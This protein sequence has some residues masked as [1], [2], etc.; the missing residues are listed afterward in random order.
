MWMPFFYDTLMVYLFFFKIKSVCLE[1]KILV[2][3]QHGSINSKADPSPI[4]SNDASSIINYKEKILKTLVFGMIQKK[5]RTLSLVWCVSSWRHAWGI[6][7]ELSTAREI[8]RPYC[9]ISPRLMPWCVSQAI[10]S[11]SFALSPFRNFPLSL[12]AAAVFF[13]NSLQCSLVYRLEIQTS[14]RPLFTVLLSVIYSC[15]SR[16][17][18]SDWGDALFRFMAP[19][20]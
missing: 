8:T 11:V 20:G 18:S 1:I 10:I 16:H 19:A 4:G 12:H 15:V 7:H 17:W 9:L 3:L 2:I 5:R 14:V 6:R 13:L